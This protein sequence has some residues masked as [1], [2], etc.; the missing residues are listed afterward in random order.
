MLKTVPIKTKDFQ[1][2]LDFNFAKNTGKLVELADGVPEFSMGGVYAV[3]GE[4]LGIIRG[5]KYDRNEAGKIIVDADG[6]PRSTGG[7]DQVLG[8][9]QADW[10][11][12][13]NLN[14][15]YKGIF[16]STLFSIKQGGEIISVSE[17]GATSSGT[18]ARTA[19]ND[20]MAFFV[21]GVTADGGANNVMVQAQDYWM[22]VAGIDEDF[23]YDA[24]YMK[25]K[26]I[27]LGYNVPVS[28]LNKISKNP[29]KSMR[30]SFVGRNLFY[31]Y[32]HTPGTAPDA[33]A[34]SSAYGAQ[35]YDFSPVP[36]ARTYGF[37]LKMG[38]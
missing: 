14:A 2:G 37:S 32:K 9:I 26:E 22:K 10:T 5:T 35:A 7:N 12:S 36:S 33:S 34:Y 17:Q 27:A 8:N 15:E 23:V 18:A 16:F 30:I 28:L 1:L 21:D 11:G 24:S 31:L 25:L 38:F 6:F 20:R 19:Q 29:V 4:K 13:I 3:P